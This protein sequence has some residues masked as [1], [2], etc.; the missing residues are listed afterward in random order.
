MKHSFTSTRGHSLEVRESGRSTKLFLKIDETFKRIDD[1]SLKPAIVTALLQE[2]IKL[3]QQKD[4]LTGQVEYLSK[5]FDKV[6]C[7]DI[8][9]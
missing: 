7:R 4:Y 9:V 1:Q 5:E 6:D 8:P 2:I 3:S